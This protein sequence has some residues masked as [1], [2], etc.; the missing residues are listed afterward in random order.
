M[1]SVHQHLQVAVIGAGPAGLGALLALHKIE[2]VDVQVYEQAREL[3]EVGAV[4]VFASSHASGVG[5]DNE[6]N[7][8]QGISLHYNTWTVLE[9]LGVPYIPS[10]SFH[11][12]ADRLRSELWN[13]GTGALLK[14]SY[15]SRKPSLVL[16]FCIDD[17]NCTRLP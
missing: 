17:T 10:E 12:N 5:S 11:R 6:A 8:L 3:R 9:K 7:M 1:P 4:G 13:G 15:D 14:A 2:G 16:C